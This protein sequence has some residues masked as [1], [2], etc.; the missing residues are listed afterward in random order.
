MY[1]Y[2]QQVKIRE[3][4]VYI[5]NRFTVQTILAIIYVIYRKIYTTRKADGELAKV[6]KKYCP[7]KKTIKNGNYC[8]FSRDNVVKKTIAQ[9]V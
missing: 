8:K 6:Y 7:V 3:K 4:H 1:I 2:K 5:L 9:V